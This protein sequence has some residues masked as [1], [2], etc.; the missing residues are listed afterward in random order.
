MKDV[1]CN[2]RANWATRTVVLKTCIGSSLL[3]GV[4]CWH[5]NAERTRA[6]DKLQRRF[7]KYMMN[8][9]KK[10]EDEE[11]AFYDGLRM[12]TKKLMLRHNVIPWS[13]L[14]R[15]RWWKWTGHRLRMPAD[16]E[17]VSMGMRPCLTKRMA[18]ERTWEWWTEKR[19]MSVQQ[20]IDEQAVMPQGGGRVLEYECDWTITAM[21]GSGWRQVAQNR[22]QWQDAERMFVWRH[23]QTQKELRADWEEAVKQIT[24]AEAAKSVVVQALL[25][26]CPLMGQVSKKRKQTIELDTL[27]EA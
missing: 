5:L 14:A 4:E 20:R 6:L 19:L 3:W 22:L 7:L 23:W 27:V 1:L 16:I 8:W 24:P 10:E 18:H 26:K 25:G 13:A 21:I 17:A 12:A 15:Q 2:T 11:A 9:T